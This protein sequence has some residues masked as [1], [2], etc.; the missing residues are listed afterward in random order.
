MK[1]PTEKLMMQDALDCENFE[2]CESCGNVYEVNW[3]KESDDFND[4]GMRYCPFCG[5]TEF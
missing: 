2:A 1:D 5:H 3:L 4:F